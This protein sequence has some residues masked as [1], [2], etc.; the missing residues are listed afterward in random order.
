MIPH[1]DSPQKERAI[2]TRDALRLDQDSL[3]DE[4][5]IKLE[6]VR[7][8][9]A[10]VVCESPVSPETVTRLQ[11]ELIPQRPWLGIVRQYFRRAN[12]ED[13]RLIELA[14]AKLPVIDE[15]LRPWFSAPSS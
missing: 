4:R 1:P 10:V 11:E 9:L 15:W 7:F 14:K 13:A 3:A 8:L 12:G 5:R 6:T 2:A